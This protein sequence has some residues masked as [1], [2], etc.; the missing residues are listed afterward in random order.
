MRSGAAIA[1]AASLLAATTL[2]A[3]VVRGPLEDV[4]GRIV[5]QLAEQID[6]TG[7]PSPV[8]IDFHTEKRFGGPAGLLASVTRNESTFTLSDW[9]LAF[10]TGPVP[11]VVT[12]AF[13]STVLP[14]RVGVYEL[15]IRRSGIDDRYR[16][17]LERELI[18]VAPIGVPR[19]SITS[20][21]LLRRTIPNTFA[22][23]CNDATWVCARVFRE[24]GLVSGI[25]PF[26][27]PSAGRNSFGESIAS[28]GR[29]PPRY[30]RYTD[31]RQVDSARAALRR[32]YD[33]LRGPQSE[34]SVGLRLWLE[35]A[36]WQW[37][38]GLGPSPSGR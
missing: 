33:D 7:R 13:G 21:T 18:R 22:V 23:R 14:I 28:G 3:Q 35:D 25:R 27:M 5:F 30:F 38:L 34:A 32:A 29:E 10:S 8:R 26:P 9:Q 4:D 37:P 11:A 12:P 15:V 16:L 17:T 31:S 2:G 1:L 19:V 24:L 6:S 36:L 20:D